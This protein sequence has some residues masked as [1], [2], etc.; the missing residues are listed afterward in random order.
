MEERGVA[1]HHGQA[2]KLGVELRESSGLPAVDDDGFQSWH[3]LLIARCQG[4]LTNVP[5]QK[6]SG[7]AADR[8]TT[9]A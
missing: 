7:S 4:I 2:E 3:Q 8:P 6:A 9:N 1:A 5:P